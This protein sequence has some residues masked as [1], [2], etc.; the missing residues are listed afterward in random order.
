M[1]N[2]VRM[3]NGKPYTYTMIKIGTNLKLIITC[4]TFCIS[5]TL[6]ADDF[7]YIIHR[8]FLSPLLQY[9]KTFIWCTYS[10]HRIQCM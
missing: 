9:L 10:H 4:F 3:E 6:W 2:L 8:P 5:I 7:I 1:I